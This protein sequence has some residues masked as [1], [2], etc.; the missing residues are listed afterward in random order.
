MSDVLLY[1]AGPNKACCNGAYC[2]Q[3]DY[4][5]QL[6]QLPCVSH[7]PCRDMG[8]GNF[9]CPDKSNSTLPRYVEFETSKNILVSKKYFLTEKI[10]IFSLR[11]YT[12]R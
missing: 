3:Q 12:C 5:S 4:F 11:K 10:F 8:Y 2:C 6:Q 9:C 7:Q 1:V